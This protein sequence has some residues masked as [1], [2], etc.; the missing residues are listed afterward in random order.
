MPV[1]SA[2]Q[3]KSYLATAAIGSMWFQPKSSTLPNIAT[4]SFTDLVDMEEGIF[5]LDQGYHRQEKSYL[6]TGTICSMWLQHK[7]ST[8][9]TIATLSFMDFIDMEYAADAVAWPA[10]ESPIVG[11]T[12]P[13]LCKTLRP[14][15]PCL[16]LYAGLALATHTRIRYRFGQQNTLLNVAHSHPC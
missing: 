3:E 12:L 9:P 11:V 10:T 4:V 16:V 5:G 1:M 14:G 7:G 6:A 15:M 8:Q 2:M 13:L